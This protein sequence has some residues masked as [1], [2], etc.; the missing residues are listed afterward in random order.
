M[1]M[2]GGIWMAVGALA[3]AALQ[4]VRI[5]VARMTQSDF[6]L[7]A[8]QVR[9]LKSLWRS[10]YRASLMSGRRHASEHKVNIKEQA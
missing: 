3:V 2:D 10:I 9:S 8:Q 6:R 7:L 4:L 1:S 5:L